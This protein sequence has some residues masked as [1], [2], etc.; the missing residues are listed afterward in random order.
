MSDKHSELS[1]L[2]QYF[3]R[4]RGIDRDTMIEL[5]TNSLRS[6]ARKAAQQKRDL[7]VKFDEEKS[8]FR[9]WAKLAVVE[10]VEDDAEE[11]TLIE[12]R[13]IDP[14][15]N[16]GDEIEIEVSSKELGRI[17][18]QMGK[19][20]INQGLRQAE[21]R[22]ICELYKEHLFQL[23]NGTV[24]NADRNE[25]AINFGQA[26]GVLRYQDRIPGETYETGDHITAL[27][28]EINPDKP[29]PSLYVSR[30]HPDFVT[31][32]FEREVTE[33]ADGL[34]EIKGLA[35]E[36]GYRT[37]IAVHTD[38]AR[39]D[40][41][42][43]CVG[44]RGNRVKTIVRELSGEKIDII[45]W[46][47]N[48]AKFVENALKPAELASVEV[49]E[50]KRLVKIKVNEDELSL[51]IGKRGQNAR[52][53]SKLTGW[54]IDIDKIEKTVD[55]EPDGYQE[56]F[57]QAVEK[58]AEQAN[59]EQEVAELLVSN[60]FNSLEVIADSNLADL[61]KLEGLDEE[62]ARQIYALANEY[63]QDDNQ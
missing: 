39:I 21:K 22:N 18:A 41:V 62:L 61:E 17:A 8:Q 59:I 47:P 50:E 3:E 9:C 30:S 53:A 54:K 58:L 7:I 16:Y 4:E 42:G 5:L 32:L 55:D 6:G 63:L 48:I 35:R 43:A 46:D 37:K 14:E 56:L 49:N 27:L 11:I 26:E 60:G 24:R 31:R 23:V 36:A 15:A 13:K 45:N 40:P 28:T 38:E 2:L 34:V 29:G 10:E 20:I 19:Q 44:L 1:A 51:A 33:I 52:L 57:Q 12:A 25:V